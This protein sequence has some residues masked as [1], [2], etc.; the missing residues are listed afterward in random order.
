M[1]KQPRGL[2]AAEFFTLG[3]DGYSMHAAHFATKLAY[4]TIHDCAHGGRVRAS[5]AEKLQEWSRG[6]IKAHG[7]Y[8]SAAKTLGLAEFTASDF[9]RAGGL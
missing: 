7:V 2:P 3:I 1:N 4:S 8:I 9:K 6:A 5:T